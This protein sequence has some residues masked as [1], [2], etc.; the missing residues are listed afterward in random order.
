V[1]KG[2]NSAF[3]LV[4]VRFL[5]K[6]R[7]FKYGGIVMEIKNN[8]TL[9]LFN[10]K[11]VTCFVKPMSRVKGHTFT[12][13]MNYPLGMEPS[14]VSLD[15]HVGEILQIIEYRE[16]TNEYKLLNISLEAPEAWFIVSAQ[17]LMTL[18]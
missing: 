1:T 11:Q 3:R 14:E 9:T 13:K 8:L 15:A 7:T 10:T 6:G 17:D 18:I 4:L 2:K 12:A 5:K 16:K